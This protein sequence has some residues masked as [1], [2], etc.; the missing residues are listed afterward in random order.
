MNLE[1]HLREDKLL[2]LCSQQWLCTL[3]KYCCTL[4]L[5]SSN[6]TNFL[7]T[8]GPHSFFRMVT[9][10]PGGT[11]IGDHQVVGD[12]DSCLFIECVKV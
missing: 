2:E 11:W 6:Q 8:L 5:H 7:C 12:V 9:L 3:L 10:G 1:V 4:G